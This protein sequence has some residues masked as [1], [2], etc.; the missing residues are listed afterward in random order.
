MG[1]LIVGAALQAHHEVSA[2]MHGRKSADSKRIKNAEDVELSLL[3]KV[4]AVGEDC[5]RDMHGQK[6]EVRAGTS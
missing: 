3:G 1:T 6:V 4:G 2:R 5:E